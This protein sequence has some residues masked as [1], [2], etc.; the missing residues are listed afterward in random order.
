MPQAIE[1][2]VNHEICYYQNNWNRDSVTRCPKV[3]HYYKQ[4]IA[5]NLAT[6]RQCYVPTQSVQSQKAKKQPKFPPETISAIAEV[7]IDSEEQEVIH[8]CNSVSHTYSRL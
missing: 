8:K 4:K 7:L 1:V 5:R 6:H 2:L 3:S